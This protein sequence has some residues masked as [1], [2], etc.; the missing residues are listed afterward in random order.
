MKIIIDTRITD[1]DILEELDE[2][3]D[4]VISILAAASSGAVI[5]LT[6]EE[7]LDLSEE[8]WNGSYR[9]EP[10]REEPTQWLN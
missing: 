1:F 5:E 3:S 10:A 4:L 6:G 7:L 9:P 2:P 8:V